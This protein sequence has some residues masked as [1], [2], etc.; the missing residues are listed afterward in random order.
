MKRLIFVLMILV[1]ALSVFFMNSTAIFAE[2]EDVD[3][4]STGNE[5]TVPEGEGDS[6]TV[7]DGE[8]E[9][10]SEEGTEGGVET[11]PDDE[12]SENETT[13]GEGETTT[14]ETPKDESSSNEATGGL[15]GILAE[16]QGFDVEATIN[17]VKDKL[18]G[19]VDEIWNFIASNETY[20]N[21]ATAICAV[22]AFICIPIVIGA[23]VL[24]Y[25]AIGAIVV[26]AG[27]LTTVIELILGMLLG[28]TML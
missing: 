3:S 25:I 4:D 19:V 10:D 5:E 13:D 22:V 21:I 27:A 17:D 24:A 15:E 8:G 23:V 20:K 2:G 1:L 12:G 28:F 14:E 7:P 18:F 9:T 6:V 16:L 11:L 26:V